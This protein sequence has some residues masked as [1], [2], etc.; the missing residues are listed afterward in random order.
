MT[1]TAIDQVYP[2]TPVKVQLVIVRYNPDGTVDLYTADGEPLL[3][4][5]GNPIKN[6]RL[7]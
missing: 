6:I 3:D 4:A 1:F 2:A 5:A 7:P